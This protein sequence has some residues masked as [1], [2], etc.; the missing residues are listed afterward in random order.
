MHTLT[1]IIRA[2]P[3]HEEKVKAALLKVGDF[4]RANEPDTID[5]FVA[6]DTADP[7][8]FTTYERFTDKAAMDRHNNGAGSKGFFAE[9]GDSI[10]GPVTVVIASE[11]FER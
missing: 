10:D 8:V 6:Q 4:V 5:F 2:R 1:A 9:A 11:L 7:R 3:G